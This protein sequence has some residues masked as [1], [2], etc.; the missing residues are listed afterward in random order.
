[1]LDSIAALLLVSGV[2]L[3]VAGGYILK[4]H[5]DVALIRWVVKTCWRPHGN[6][7]DASKTLKY[8]VQR[9]QNHYQCVSVNDTP[10]GLDTITTRAWYDLA[11]LKGLDEEH[12]RAAI[13]LIASLREIPQETSTTP[14]T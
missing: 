14:T 10:K 5:K 8:I 13:D 6:S 11:S 9:H 3:A 4:S 1:M 2:L 7:K 12:A